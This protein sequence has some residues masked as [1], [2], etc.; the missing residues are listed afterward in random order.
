MTAINTI[1]YSLLSWQRNN[2][3]AYN[4]LN[5]L[6]NYENKESLLS[7]REGGLFYFLPF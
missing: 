5:V 3:E 1:V 2:F 6:L 7:K 4:A